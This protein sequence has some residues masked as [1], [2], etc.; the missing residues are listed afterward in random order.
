MSVEVIYHRDIQLIA[1]I[2]MARSVGGC[3]FSMFNVDALLKFSIL[4]G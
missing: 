4:S 1:E 3:D 2:F